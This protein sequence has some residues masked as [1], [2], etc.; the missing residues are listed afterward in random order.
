MTDV[1]HALNTEVARH[2][3]QQ[4]VHAQ[5]IA[6]EPVV[7]FTII[8]KEDKLQHP[9]RP[10]QTTQVIDADKRQRLHEMKVM[11]GDIHHKCHTKQGT[12]HRPVDDAPVLKNIDKMLGYPR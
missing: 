11:S 12:G 1:A 2:D 7:V 3:K 9:C 8:E 5:D 4:H 10:Q 6:V